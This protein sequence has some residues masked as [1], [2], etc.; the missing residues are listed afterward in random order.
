M[1]FYPIYV[2]IGESLTNHLR[3]TRLH[4]RRFA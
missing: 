4:H 3:H 2:E 1:I